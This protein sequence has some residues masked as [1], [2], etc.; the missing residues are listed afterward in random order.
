MHCTGVDVSIKRD[1]KPNASWKARNRVRRQGLL[2]I[3]LVLIG[4][5]GSLVAYLGG[6]APATNATTAQ[7][8]PTPGG[9]PQASAP[10]QRALPPNVAPPKPKYD[11]YKV[12]PEREL[13]IRKDELANRPPPRPSAPSQPERT[14]TPPPR[15][16]ATTSP[17][18]SASRRYVVQ[19]GSFQRYADADRLKASLAFLGIQA[20]IQAAPAA[21]GATWHR[22]R[23]GPVTSKQ[24]AEDLRKRL[25]DNNIQSIALTAR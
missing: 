25:R 21:N 12:L 17:K 8:Q 24:Q 10:P 11:F 18:K 5:I 1:Y 3:A 14:E 7:P 22:V 9:A 15:Q 20:Y 2:V 19:A 6:D 13:V 4:L 23:I 16:A